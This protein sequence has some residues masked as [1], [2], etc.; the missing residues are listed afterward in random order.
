[1]RISLEGPEDHRGG[2]RKKKKGKKKKRG[3]GERGR[4]EKEEE[5]KA[6]RGEGGRGKGR[7]RKRKRAREEGERRRGRGGT[8][9]RSVPSGPRPAAAELYK[10]RLFLP[11]IFLFFL[12]TSG[13]STLPSFYKGNMKKELKKK[14]FFQKS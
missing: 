13:T 7:G 3:E 14:R 8:F 11:H 9:L 5:K 12:S 10:N 4:E 1:M 2:R 6:D